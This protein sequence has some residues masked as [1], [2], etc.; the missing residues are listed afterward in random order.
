[1]TDLSR[2]AVAEDR[3]V[4][5]LVFGQPHDLAAGVAHRGLANDGVGRQVIERVSVHSDDCARV[6]GAAQ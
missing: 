2:A 5:E 6:E 1:M 4:Q 3:F